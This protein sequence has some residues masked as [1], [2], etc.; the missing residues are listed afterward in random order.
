M[1]NKEFVV[2]SPRAAYGE[3]LKELGAQNPNIVVLDADLSCSTQTKIFAKE[4]PER[5][6]NIGIAEQNLITTAVGLSLTNKIPFAS[7]FAV[8]ATGRC[9]DQIRS[10]VCYSNTNVKIV[11][12]HGGITVGEDGAT[13]QALEDI[14][15]MRSLPNMN[16][17]SPADYTEVKAIVKYAASLEAPCYIRVPRNNVPTVFNEEKYEFNPQSAVE[18]YSGTDVL[19]V[20]TGEMLQHSIEACKIL[21]ENKIHPKLLHIPQIKPFSAKNDIIESAK[22]CKH[23]VSIEN[24]SVI[25]G[26]GSQVAETLSENYPTKLLRIGINDEF[27]QSGEASELIKF[28]GLDSQSIAKKIME[29]IKWLF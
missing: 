21:D 22:A 9:Y 6:F 10:S 28:Y 27:G 1:L 12:T 17:F 23:V 5:F 13:H 20:T 7:T 24:H 3:A 29:F 16:V 2:K 26:L 14:S 11:G 18:I 8:F 15:L 19:L 25:G 4:F